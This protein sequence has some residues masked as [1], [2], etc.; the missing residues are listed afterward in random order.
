MVLK[1]RVFAEG[2]HLRPH[3]LRQGGNP[4]EYHP[5]LT[6]APNGK[7]G[8][9]RRAR[10]KITKLRKKILKIKQKI[11]YIFLFKKN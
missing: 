7:V 9:G 4:V 8:G 1:G 3:C 6:L 10:K 5:S 2:E 11:K